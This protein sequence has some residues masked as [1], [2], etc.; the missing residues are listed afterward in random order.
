MGVIFLLLLVVGLGFLGHVIYKNFQKTSREEEIMAKASSIDVEALRRDIEEAKAAAEEVLK[1]DIEEANV[2]KLNLISW[3]C[4]TEHGYTSIRGEVENIT[5]HPL[6][7]VMVVGIF[8]TA[9]KVLVKSGDALL[10]YNPIMPGQ[11]SPFRAMVTENPL[12]ELCSVSFKFLM[13]GRIN[14]KVEYGAGITSEID[15]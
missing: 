1:R 4:D 11:T 5:D 3:K 9:D 13:G 14:T 12:I 7:N 2:A 15:E 6:K 10:K 8:K